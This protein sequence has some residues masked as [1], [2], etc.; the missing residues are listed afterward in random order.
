MYARF[1]GLS[2]VSFSRFHEEHDALHDDARDAFKL[3]AVPLNALHAQSWHKFGVQAISWQAFGWLA[4]S[5]GCFLL[6]RAAVTLRC[7]FA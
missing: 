2:Y 5:E 4:V 3:C 6:L 1:P 7:G